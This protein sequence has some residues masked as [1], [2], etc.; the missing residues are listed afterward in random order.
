MIV[1]FKPSNQLKKNLIRINVSNFWAKIDNLAVFFLKLDCYYNILPI[2]R[3]L[4]FLGGNYFYRA[5]FELCGIEIV[6]LAALLKY[7][8]REEGEGRTPDSP[9]YVLFLNSYMVV[10]SS[11]NSGL[12]QGPSSVY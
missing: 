4:I 5:T 9:L 2:S 12:T 11:H 1:I 10:Y 7:R 6:H 8:A 3:L